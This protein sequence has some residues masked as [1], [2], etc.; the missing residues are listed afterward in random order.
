MLCD[1]SPNPIIDTEMNTFL[2]LWKE[3]KVKNDIKSSL[4]Q[5]GLALRVS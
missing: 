1:G 4:A 5:I 2:A 3:D